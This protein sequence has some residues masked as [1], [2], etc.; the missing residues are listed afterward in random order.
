[1]IVVASFVLIMI[2]GSIIGNTPEGKERQAEKDKIARCW[3]IQNKKSLDSST[4]RF[5]A[6]L[7]EKLEDDYLKKWGRKP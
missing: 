4:A 5:A 3:E 1:M 2:V 6:E 7:C